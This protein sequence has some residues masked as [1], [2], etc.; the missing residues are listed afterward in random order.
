MRCRICSSKKAPSTSTVLVLIMPCHSWNSKLLTAQFINANFQFCNL[1][2][3]AVCKGSFCHISCIAGWTGFSQSISLHPH[4]TCT[5]AHGTCHILPTRNMRRQERISYIL[6]Y[7]MIWN[8]SLYC[9]A[10]H[11]A[12][13]LLGHYST[14]HVHN[15]TSLDRPQVDRFLQNHTN[16]RN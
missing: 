5:A 7:H 16:S 1:G 11:T 8:R 15:N 12:L 2:D 3:L 13:I 10:S 4:H 9:K 6:Q 14:Y